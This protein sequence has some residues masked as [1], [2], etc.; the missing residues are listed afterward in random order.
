MAHIDINN[1]TDKLQL[2]NDKMISIGN[3][4]PSYKGMSLYSVTSHELQFALIHE[5]ILQFNDICLLIINTDDNNFKWYNEILFLKSGRLLIYINNRHLLSAKKIDDTVMLC[6]TCRLEDDSMLNRSEIVLKFIK[7]NNI[8]DCNVLYDDNTTQ[9]TVLK[10]GCD[11]MSL[12]NSLITD[13][14]YSTIEEGEKM[15]AYLGEFIIDKISNGKTPTELAN[16]FSIVM[17]ESYSI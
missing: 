3:M 9:Q 6:D 17:S 1:Y 15:R 13:N 10:G 7:D 2:L 5:F 14:T 11:V 4:E 8:F 12:C 16:D